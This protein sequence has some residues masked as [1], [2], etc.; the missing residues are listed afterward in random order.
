MNSKFMALLL[1]C[2][3][4]T[5]LANAQVYYSTLLGT[6]RDATGWV[7][8][9]TGITAIEVRTGVATSA[10]TGADG[11]YRIATLRPGIYNISVT[12][13]NFKTG[14]IK[15]IEL[16]V[17]QTTRIDIGLEVGDVMQK[18]AVEGHAPL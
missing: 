18:V 3:S 16:F 12:K 6:V 14:T 10:T 2:L 5:T 17:G 8:S 15:D 13:A 11:D 9:E 1:T 4:I 7:I